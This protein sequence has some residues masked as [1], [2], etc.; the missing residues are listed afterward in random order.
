MGCRGVELEGICRKSLRRGCDYPLLTF[1]R[2]PDNPARV[3]RHQRT[4]QPALGH[5]PVGDF[6][7]PDGNVAREPTSSRRV[8]RFVLFVVRGVLLL[9]LPLVRL[10]EEKSCRTC[11]RVHVPRRRRGN[12]LPSAGVQRVPV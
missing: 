1:R 2:Q 6:S 8:Y 7:T 4:I 12:H 5:V 11:P 10:S 3:Q 9:H